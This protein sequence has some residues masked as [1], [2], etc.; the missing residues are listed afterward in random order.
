MIIVIVIVVMIIQSVFF[1]K[2][3]FRNI[4]DLIFYG[5]NKI[6]KIILKNHENLK[7]HTNLFSNSFF[8]KYSRQFK[9]ARNKLL[10]LIFYC[11]V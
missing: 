4:F 5:F 3:I 1:V 11:L 6:T 7:I 2:I 9:I 10:L 8:C